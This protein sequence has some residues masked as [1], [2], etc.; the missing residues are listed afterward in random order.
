M[1]REF[2]K[3]ICKYPCIDY[4]MKIRLWVCWCCITCYFWCFYCSCSF[5]WS[6]FCLSFG[7][8]ISCVLTIIHKSNGCKIG[9]QAD[10]KLCLWYPIYY[11][12]Y[13]ISIHILITYL[14]GEYVSWRHHGGVIFGYL[15][16]IRYISC[17]FLC[18]RLDW[19]FNLGQVFQ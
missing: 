18:A 4:C 7:I 10:E 19:K 1:D 11:C 2:F 9:F 5:S 8:Y 12:L 3:P 15:C 17:V 14:F 16:L 6:L 13:F